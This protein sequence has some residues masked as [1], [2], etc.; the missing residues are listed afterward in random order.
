MAIKVVDIHPH[1][2]SHDTTRYPLSPIGGKRSDWSAERHVDLEELIAAMDKAG[3][4]KA[5]V[6]HSSTT[7]GFNDEYVCDAVEKYPKRLVA[8]FSVD[9]TQPDSPKA[10]KHWH[11][12]HTGGMRIYARGS[13]MAE[14]WLQIDAPECKPAWDTCRELGISVALNVQLKPPG[15]QQLINVL[16]R[17]PDI[18]IILDHLSRPK[19]EDGYPYNDAKPLWDM[20]KYKNFYLKASPANF[21]QAMKGKSTAADFFKRV[22]EVYGSDR[23][24]WGSNF[25]AEPEPLD[26]LVKTCTESVASLPQKDVENLFRNTALKL[27]PALKD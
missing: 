3:V 13:T 1:I 20:A 8:V 18:P 10:I 11:S 17:Y 22:F 21:T 6:V 16:E 4:D 26:E 9:I 2:V 12:R 27:Y 19:V 25:P 5:A 7:Y 15:H 23:V 14:Q 24:A